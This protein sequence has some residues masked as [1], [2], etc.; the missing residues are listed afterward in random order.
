MS[1]IT[2]YHGTPN[3]FVTPQYGYGEDKHDYGKGFYLTENMELAKE[4]AV[5]R[6]TETNGWVHKYELDISDLKIL[7]FQKYDVFSWLAELMKHRDA[8]DTKRYK[9][10]SKKFIEKFGIDTS[11]YD[12]IKGWRANASYFYIAK[13]FV[14]DNVDTD[15]LEELLSLG[16]L[17]IQYCIKSELAYSKLTENK[18]GLIRVEYSV[19]NDKYNQRDVRARE[20]MHDLIES[21]T[22]DFIN[23][24]MASKTRESIDQGKAYVS[25]MNAAELWDYFQQTEHYH[26]KNGKALKGFIPDWI[27][28]F[29]AYYQWFYNVSSKEIIKKVPLDFLTKAYMGLHDL[30]LD[31]AVKKVGGAP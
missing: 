6:P 24:Y 25:T 12:V 17:G 3:E 2:L 4:W 19:F 29:Y 22:L 21:D 10:L 18:E 1:I 14:R 13:E 23:A 5:C 20:N 28:E 27:G 30:E 8:A 11:T 31:L 9:V 7:D 15:I 26:L 16:G